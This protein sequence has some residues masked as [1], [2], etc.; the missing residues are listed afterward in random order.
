MFASGTMLGRYRI[1]S[2]LGEGQ[3][4]VVYLAF[5]TAIERTVAIKC[6][7]TLAPRRG[8]DDDNNGLNILFKEAKL[9]GQLSHP[10]ITAVFDMG[11]S[12]TTPYIVMEYVHGQTLKSRLRTQQDKAPLPL[13]L[14][15]IVMV[16]RALHY[17]HQRGILHGDIN[18]ANLIVTPQGTP[19]IMDF[20]VARRHLAQ[21]PAKWSMEGEEFIWGT[22]GYLAP[23]LLVGQEIDARADVF[24]LGAIA[25]EWLSGT[26]PFLG[27]NAESAKKALLEGTVKPLSELGGFDSE[28]SN[29]IEQALARDPGKRFSSANE[30]ADAL[31]TYLERGLLRAPAESGLPS[32][33]RNSSNTFPRLKVKNMLFADFSETDLATVMQMA[34]QETYRE[35]ATIV[36][37]GAGGSMMYLVVRGRVSVRKRSGEQEIEIK[38]IAAGECFGE[39]SVISQLPR[40][41]SVVAM[42]PTEV[43][44]ISGAVLRSESP[45]ISMKLYR[46][47]AAML[48]ERVRQKDEE[49]LALMKNQE[50][51]RPAKRKFPFW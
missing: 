49:L 13:I 20:G 33:A 43:I 17:V 6:L 42:R 2:T 10:N 38:Q 18:P 29:E 41:A 35:G 14:S 12:A 26:N 7:K 8:Q 15:F 24:S 4:G 51:R 45:I 36:Q 46:N 30:L 23:E 19:K 37:E 34:R 28:L 32:P 16:A 39:M 25:Y 5:D 11:S 9:I 21:G 48:S 3:S 22:P 27:R 1:E 50:P 47:I 40:S 31:E 44:A